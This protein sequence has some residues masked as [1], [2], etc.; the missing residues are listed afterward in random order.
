MR[1]EEHLLDTGGRGH[2]EVRSLL[3]IPHQGNMQSSLSEETLAFD[4]VEGEAVNK[5][6]GSRISNHI[7]GNNARAVFFVG[8]AKNDG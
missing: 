2:V 7:C 1:R 3:T 5:E 8:L 6:Y 4:K